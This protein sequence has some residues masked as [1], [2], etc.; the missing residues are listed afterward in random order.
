MQGPPRHLSF[1]DD[2]TQSLSLA[3]YAQR[4]PVFTGGNRVTL[5]RGGDELFPAMV[6][7]IDAAQESIW[8][9]NYLTGTGGQADRV[10]DALARAARRGVAV[11]VVMDG[12]GSRE[13]PEA[14][15]QGLRS[16]GIQ[17]AIYRPVAGLLSA[18]NSRNWRRMH[19]KLCVADEDLAFVGGINLI[20][21]HNDLTHG[22]TSG[23]PRLDYA[24]QVHGPAATPV[25]HTVRA[26]W[27]RATLGRDWRDDLIDWVK[28]PGRMKRLRRVWQQA[29]LRLPPVEQGQISAS[30]GIRLPMRAAFVLRDNLRQRRTIERASLQAIQQARSTV[31]IVTPYFYPGRALRRALKHAADRGVR[32][33]LLLQG[34]VDYRIAA[35]AARA[36]YDELQAHGVRIF[37]YQPSWLHAKVLCVDDEWATVGSSNLDPLSML[38][39][40]E[41]NL[42]VRDRGFAKT[43][44]AALARDFADSV[45][46][47]WASDVAQPRSTRWMRAALNW[48]AKLYLRLAG[49]RRRD[50]R[51]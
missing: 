12:V 45:E 13:V 26:M 16:Q 17:L 8:L 15:W 14:F 46:V 49:V 51:D 9:A 43:L 28:V 18:L 33:R 2:A 36:L 40:L 21:D 42:I 34:K 4:R 47:P 5:L 48:G 11:Q 3:W 23:P 7:A 50:W 32:V 38:V 10:F 29:R 24:V 44:G 41:G 27:T 30:A 31:D 25:Q 35:I 37:E 22:W 39:N 1:G 19:L 20:D 6:Q